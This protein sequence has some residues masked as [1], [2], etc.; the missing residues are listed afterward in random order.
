M[1]NAIE[2]PNAMPHKLRTKIYKTATPLSH[3]PLP[4]K[5]RNHGSFQHHQPSPLTPIFSPRRRLTGTGSASQIP[6]RAKSSAMNVPENTNQQAA[7]KQFAVLSR[8]RGKVE[9]NKA[10]RRRVL[11]VLSMEIPTACRKKNISGPRGFVSAI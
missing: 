8:A 1:S 3:Q 7:N 5:Y 2:N 9:G 6:P 4:S 11:N 10:G